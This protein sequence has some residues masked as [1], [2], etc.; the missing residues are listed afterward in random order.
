VNVPEKMPSVKSSTS[1]SIGYNTS[2]N[3]SVA[4][5]KKLH[6]EQ[7]SHCQGNKNS[8]TLVV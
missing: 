3:S 7:V 2:A 6:T 4:I 8:K 1:T 5:N